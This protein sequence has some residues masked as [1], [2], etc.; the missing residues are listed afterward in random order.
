MIFATLGDLKSAAPLPI[1]GN[2][3]SVSSGHQS[4]FKAVECANAIKSTSYCDFGGNLFWGKTLGRLNPKIPV[5]NSNIDNYVGNHW[6]ELGRDPGILQFKQ[7]Y[8]LDIDEWQ[9]CS[10]EH[11]EVW[12]DDWESATPFEFR[13]AP[14]RAC[15]RDI[16][17]GHNDEEHMKK[18][19]ALF[20][21]CSSQLRVVQKKAL[22]NGHAGCPERIVDAMHV[23]NALPFTNDFGNCSSQ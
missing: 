14:I 18:W 15:A 12:K 19:R 7:V 6:P 22:A 8:V 11:W 5:M 21:R 16:R 20:L 10:A 4:Q 3:D 1:R 23:R 9:D 17:S 13:A 2:A